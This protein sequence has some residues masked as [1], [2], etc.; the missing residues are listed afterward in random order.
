DKYGERWESEL[1][2]EGRSVI[3]YGVRNAAS[4]APEEIAVEPSGSR[5]TV[6]GQ[7]YQLRLPGRFN[8]WNALAAIGVARFLGVADATGARALSELERVPGRMERFDAGE[9]AVV[10][11]YAHTPDALESALR[12]LRE[13]TSGALTV[14][15]GCGGDRDRGKRPE[16][17][18]VAAV[19]ADRLYVTSDNPRNED[20]QAIADAIVAG[21]GD[22]DRIV[23]LD[24]RRAIERAIAQA[25]AGDVVLIAGKG[26]EMYQIVG[27]RVLPFDDAAVAREALG[28]RSVLR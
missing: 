4:L 7:R 27:D 6:N 26:H 19:F 23:E 28:S 5:F 14:V 22:R 25:R 21:I 9:I 24:R 17:G 3:T 10:V 12:S 13:T 20:P 1:R 16:M 8:I 11:D 15:F 2:R 18:A